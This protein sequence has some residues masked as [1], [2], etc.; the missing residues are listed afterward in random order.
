MGEI[1]MNTEK[2][3]N[4]YKEYEEKM[5]SYTDHIEKMMI[6]KKGQPI[7]LSVMIV[8][9]EKGVG[10]SYMADKILSNQTIRK[11]NICTD[12]VSPVEL[13]KLLWH[14]NDSIIVLDDISGILTD[15]KDGASVLKAATET[16]HM[17]S[18]EWRKQNHL[19][20]PVSSHHPADND[21]V[22]RYIA[23]YIEDNKFNK[24]LLAKHQANLTFPDKFYFTGSIIIL[25]NKPLSLID[26]YSEGA[27]SNRGWH[28][29][30]LFT[31]EGAIDLL[32]HSVNK[33]T[34]FMDTKISITNVRKALAFMT[35]KE[36]IDYYRRS[37]VI[38]TLRNLGKIALE[39]Q[40]GME[41]NRN[42]LL[43]NTEP[44]AY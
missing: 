5:K 14:N 15:P 39:I 20:I 21:E 16:K 26:R 44:S 28:Q 31:V 25:T 17:R 30:M 10:K 2:R 34:Y 22:N 32:K 35:T 23:A 12:A 41:I 8:S 40:N 4:S 19:C 42:L 29:E 43:N 24:K 27:I 11:Y 38:P 36:A 9:G 18:I 7:P 37:N 13:V 6:G 3:I 33:M 1:T